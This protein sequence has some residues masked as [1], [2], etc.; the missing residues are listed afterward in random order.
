MQLTTYQSIFRATCPAARV[1]LRH[2]AQKSEHHAERKLC[3]R[4]IGITGRIA[5]LNAAFSARG[6][7]N[8]I[9]ASE[10]NIDIL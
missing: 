8:V 9:H 7:I 6:K 2:A 4:A 5:Y 10:C 1:N 3:N